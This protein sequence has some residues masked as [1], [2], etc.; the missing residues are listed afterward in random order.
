[1][2]A[3]YGQGREGARYQT[4]APERRSGDKG[5]STVALGAW[6]DRGVPVRVEDAWLD[7]RLRSKA[8]AAARSR[9]C[10]GDVDGLPAVRE[11]GRRRR[12][13]ARGAP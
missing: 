10:A 12:E 6:Q 7:I 13:V 11:V 3:G 8:D 9:S 2:S 4:E 5:G 1:M